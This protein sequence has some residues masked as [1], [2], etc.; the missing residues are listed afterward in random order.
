LE[1]Y[2]RIM[3]RGTYLSADTF[4]MTPQQ[5]WNTKQAFRESGAK[6]RLPV[7]P[8][9]YQFLRWCR[10]HYHIVLLT[11]RPIDEY[12][13]MYMDTLDWLHY[14]QLPFDH[15]WWAMDKSDALASRPSIVDRV[16]FAVDDD[17]RFVSQLAQWG[18]PVY[19]L[20]HDLSLY[21]PD[22]RFITRVI[23]LEEVMEK[24][25]HT[26]TS[27]TPDTGPTPDTPAKNPTTPSATDPTTSE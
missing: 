5:W 24:V 10:D 15:I 11:S 18:F 26:W 7:M 3:E 8:G 23:S 17:P 20:V 27:K 4:G 25:E 16:R 6:A 22:H 14:N 12:P 19:H 21:T 9:A 2:N 1:Q 13:G